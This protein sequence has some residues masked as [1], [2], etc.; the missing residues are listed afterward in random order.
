MSAIIQFVKSIPLDQSALIVPYFSGEAD[1]QA[2][3]AAGEVLSQGARDFIASVVALKGDGGFTGK[4]GAHLSLYLPAEAEEGQR[5]VIL[6]GLGDAAGFDEA[7]AEELGGML[8]ACL[9]AHKEKR[10]VLL[11]EGTPSA[12]RILAGFK[13]RSYV[14]DRY[15]SVS[16]DD[17]AET[18]TL[19][20]VSADS[21]AIRAGY[22]AL[23]PVLQGVFLARDLV[24]EAPNVLYP[25]SYAELIIDELQPLGVSV[26]VLDEKA[27]LK[28][29]MGGIMAVGQGSARQPRMV[30]MRWT[31]EGVSEDVK[32][33]A[34]VGKGVTFDTGG[35][36]LKPGAG[37]DEMK[38][39][40]GGSA[41]VVGAM[42]AIAARKAK[43]HVVGIVGLA[44]NMPSS[45]AYRP[46]DIITTYAGK[47]IEVLNTDAEGRL[48]LS[49][50]LAYVQKEYDPELVVDLATLTGAMMVALGHE[51]CGTF[52]NDDGLWDSLSAASG[53]GREKL[54]RMPLDDVWLKEMESDVA[55]LRNIGKS[56]FA[57]SCTAAAFLQHFIDDGRKW[58]HMDIAGTA[59]VKEVRAT[60]P[61]YG[62]GFG[63]RTLDRL[64]K[65]VHEDA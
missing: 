57:G 17:T 62:Q 39:D 29:G 64:V 15:K 25:Q 47:T 50:A 36:S 18:A 23:E 24:N 4:K 44:E 13:L 58:A 49:D 12:D 27:M 1:G 22:E 3:Y 31:G 8:N 38:M 34:L 54:W 7:R 56:R 5:R 32:P 65:A 48:V 53:E 46:G 10:G 21:D 43:A 52:S 37:M 51:Y 6:F 45:N 60:A 20:L 26:E 9:E 61:K 33:I 35:I 30:I 55:D 41:A 63:V 28:L 16:S 59:W 40:M 42:K 11:G 19:V 14:F 2:P